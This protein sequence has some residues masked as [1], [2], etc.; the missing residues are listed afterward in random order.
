MDLLILNHGQMRRTT[1]ELASASPSFHAIPT[2][3]CLSL[4][5]FNVYRTPSRRVFSSTRTGYEGSLHIGNLRGSFSS[6]SQWI[7]EVM[8]L[9]TNFR[10]KRAADDPPCRGAMHVK[11]VESSNVLSLVWCGS[12]ETGA[13]SGVVLLT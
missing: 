8:P 11:S 2:G 4:D 5:R 13:N 10:T 3:G 1:P 12:Q 7:D 9:A 6:E